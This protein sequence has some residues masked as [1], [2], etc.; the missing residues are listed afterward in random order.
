MKTIIITYLFFL[1]FINHSNCQNRIESTRQIV[2]IGFAE[3][4][5]IP[6][7]IYYSVELT[8]YMNG[9]SKVKMAVLDKQF[10][11]IASELGLNKED[12]SLQNSHQRM[13]R[14]RKKAEEI[15][16]SKTYEIKFL[17]I[18]DLDKFA[19]K[20]NEMR[21]SQS[22][23]TGLDFSNK[24][25][26]DH[27]LKVAALKDAKQKAEILLDELGENLGAV[28]KVE[29]NFENQV[30]SIR[31]YLFAGLRKK[32]RSNNDYI[33]LRDYYYGGSPNREETIEFKP[34]ILI[35]SIQVTFEI[36]KGR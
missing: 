5:Y 10:F 20:I 26:I 31:S 11:T 21:I 18:E 7:I 24:T 12:I 16:Q 32:K 29:E 14:V 23:I 6:D 25:E 3:N 15:L 17:S 27:Q 8:E 36:R 34:I 30:N 28:I 13:W 22:G 2:T 19:Y 35:A 33:L 1:L 9:K 4:Q